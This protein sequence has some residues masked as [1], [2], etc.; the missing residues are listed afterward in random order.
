MD[1]AIL[2]RAQQRDVELDKMAKTD[3]ERVGLFSEQGYTTIS[4]PYVP[5]TGSEYRD[6]DLTIL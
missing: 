4:D 6:I 3:M 5:P 1:T 2:Q